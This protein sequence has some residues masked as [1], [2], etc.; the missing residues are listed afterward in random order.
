MHGA[1]PYRVAIVDDEVDLTRALARAI[2]RIIPGADCRTAADGFS[3][4]VLFA[5]F[6]PQL[7]LL[8][9]VMPGMSGEVVCQRIR[10]TPTL[11]KTAVVVLTGHLTDRLE[12]RLVAAGADRCLAKP[13]PGTV[14]EAAILPFARAHGVF[15]V[16]G[17]G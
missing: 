17:A 16:E 12:T 15:L 8:D 14:L 3:A 4:G 6:L 13:C 5:S 10:A 11:A 2:S 9:V 7:V 1:I